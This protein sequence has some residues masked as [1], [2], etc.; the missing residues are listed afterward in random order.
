MFQFGAK[1]DRYLKKPKG[2]LY[3]PVN[4]NGNTYYLF[5]GKR[6]QYLNVGRGASDNPE[7]AKLNLLSNWFDDKKTKVD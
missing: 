2:V 3:T 4:Y 1:N 7:Q 6:T 5:G